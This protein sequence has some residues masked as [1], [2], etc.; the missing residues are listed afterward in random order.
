L[1]QEASRKFGFGARVMNAAQRLYEA[2][3]TYGPTVST[4]LKP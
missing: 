4:P 3:I 1:Q 2:S